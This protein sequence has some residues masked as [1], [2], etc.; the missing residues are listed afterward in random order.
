MDRISSVVTRALDFI[1]TQQ[2][3]NGSFNSFCIRDSG[4]Y[5]KAHVTTFYASLILRSL[6]NI[7]IGSTNSIKKKIS[8][9][10]IS[11]KSSISTYNYWARQEIKFKSEPYP[12]DLDDTACALAALLS[13][14]KNLVSQEDLANL[15]KILINL[16]SRE[17]G[18]YFTWIM[19]RIK[20]TKW[21][22]VDLAVN[23]NVSFFL[24]LLD[25][26]LP[27]I[28]ALIDESILSGNFNS[29]YYFSPGAILYFISQNYVGKEK[30]RLIKIIN[31][32]NNKPF[33]NSTEC[34]L[35]GLSL[36]NLEAEKA[37]IEHNIDYLLLNQQVDGSF[38]LHPFIVE[39]I[40][41]GSKRISGS[42]AFGASIAAE[43]L[44]RYSQQ[45][46]ATPSLP[47]KVTQ[48]PL[49][50]AVAI[51]T[52]KII[53]RVTVD[54]L[55]EFNNILSKTINGDKDGQI[56]L[57][58]FLF[59]ESC[60]NSSA[61]QKDKKFLLDLSSANLLGWIAYQI[62]DDII[63]EKRSTEC[64]P[65]AI[66]CNRLQEE[67]FC[68]G[69]KNFRSIFKYFMNRVDRANL[70]ESTYAKIG[71]NG[72]IPLK[73]IYPNA[74]F[75]AEKSITHCLAPLA[76]LTKMGF[77]S[78]DLEFKSLVSFYE[79]YLTAR[80]LNDDAH[81]WEA[82]L[83]RGQINYV[84]EQILKIFATTKAKNVQFPEDETALREIFWQDV[85]VTIC[86]E[87]NKKV[88]EARKNL[89]KL[90]HF[91]KE[92]YLD[93]KLVELEGAAAKALNE[94]EKTIEYLEAMFENRS[95]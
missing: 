92:D 7:K 37:N 31:D 83:K 88:Q 70:Y 43:L 3:S 61:I 45:I 11:E 80:Q 22:T 66:I 10:L 48:E 36:L 86:E 52:R 89:L 29:P 15:T 13:V 21:A 93:K 49:K 85:I 5:G 46:S 16:E 4:T 19:P 62:F 75:V 74:R 32:W 67:I 6:A 79:N 24:S 65:L 95:S 90:G 40:A 50:K 64:L 17:G 55:K 76:V 60:K 87:I 20:G 54:D 71:E 27:N 23:A 26:T 72:R 63:D 51:H 28:A 58:P 73:T 56:T 39:R 82:D 25:I 68:D 9:F 69:N 53:K 33:A 2:N 1:K 38:G 94:R 84:G 18:P 14:G 59:I 81:D 35:L 44:F 8:Y 41:S 91:L 57:H 42:S 78:E 77:T 12:D 34:A 47:A 30:A